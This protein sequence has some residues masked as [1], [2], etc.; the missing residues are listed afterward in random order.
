MKAKLA[1]WY[2]L[3]LVLGCLSESFSK[4]ININKPASFDV[5]T[6]MLGTSQS[7]SV[8][9]TMLNKDKSVPKYLTR[10]AFDQVSDK[11]SSRRL[12]EAPDKAHTTN[13]TIIGNVKKE[14]EFQSKLS[15]IGDYVYGSLLLV[16]CKLFYLT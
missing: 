11:K 9:N 1:T 5:T 14:D 15:P 8:I 12:K 16:T 13:A 7:L 4:S 2:I 10:F 3:T 6:G